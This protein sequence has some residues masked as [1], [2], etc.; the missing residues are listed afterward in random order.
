MSNYNT[1]KKLYY[2][3][4]I[5][6]SGLKVFKKKIRDLHPDIKTKEVD[7]FYKNLELQQII[8][9]PIVDKNKFLRIVDGENT[10]QIDIMIFKKSQKQQNRGYFMCLAMI[11]VLSRFVFMEL[12]KTRNTNDIINSY[13]NILKRLKND[14]NKKPVKLISDDEFNNNEFLKLNEKLNIRL[15]THIASDEHFTGG[16]SLGLIDRYTRTIKSKILKYQLSSGNINFIDVLQEIVDNYNNSSH[17]SLKD[18]SPNDVFNNKKLQIDKKNEDLIY[19]LEVKENIKLNIGTHVRIFNSK[20]IF[21]KEGQTFSKKIYSISE[22]VGNKYKVADDED[23]IKKK[24]YK[25]NELQIIEKDKIE[26][27]N[28][29]VNKKINQLKI[30]HKINEELKRDDIDK[31]KIINGKTRGDNLK[32]I[33]KQLKKLN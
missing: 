1:L 24:L 27:I 31:T 2:N 21:D 26:P 5:G 13:E 25:F 22:Q 33:N 7:E 8:K 17:S 14:Y 15:D 30:K 11:D 6:L 29:N 32:I 3:A 19:N 20:K 4:S 10:Y 23:N 28:N 9:K 12:L 18:Q 16:N